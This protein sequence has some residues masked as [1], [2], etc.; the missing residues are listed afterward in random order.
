MENSVKL[1]NII[2]WYVDVLAGQNQVTEQLISTNLAP[3]VII[4]KSKSLKINHI[5]NNAREFSQ[6]IPSNTRE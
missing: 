4:W 2:F 5:Y 6:T 3:V 1:N